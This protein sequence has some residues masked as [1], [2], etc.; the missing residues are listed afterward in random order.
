VPNEEH[1]RKL[2]RMYATARIN[3]F[4]APTLSIREGEAEIRVPVRPDFFHAAHAVHGA[5][6]FKMLD[7][8]AFFAVNSLVEDVFVLTVTFNLYLTRPIT[9]GILH[10]TGR[11][12]HSSKRLFIAESVLTDVQGKELA[13]GSGSFMRSQIALTA[14]LGYC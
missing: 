10:S 5:V 7:E 8:A 6:Y 14:D 3:T 12:V 2:E 11:V 9:A 4:F 13:R 1:F